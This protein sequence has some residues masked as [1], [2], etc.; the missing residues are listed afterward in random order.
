[1]GANIRFIV[2]ALVHLHQEH[3]EYLH[4]HTFLQ[5][6]AGG[7][8]LIVSSAVLQVWGRACIFLDSAEGD[9]C[10]TFGRKLREAS[11]ACPDRLPCLRPGMH[12]VLPVFGCLNPWVV[13]IC[14]AQLIATCL[15]GH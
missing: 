4:L 14:L 15:A 13:S 7:M 11:G 9:S 6:A 2:Q 8:L 1:M 3:P 5:P 12:Q 10:D